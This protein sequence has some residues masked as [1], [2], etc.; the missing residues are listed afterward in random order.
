VRL[1]AALHVDT[2]MFPREHGA[3]GQVAFPLVTSLAVAGLTTGPILMALAVLALFLAHEPLVI[4]LG[5]RG[6][7]ALD[8]LGVRAWVCFHLAVVVATASGVL[9]FDRTPAPWRWTFAVPMVPAA[10]LFTALIV[11]RDEKS[12]LGESSAAL[13]FSAAALPVCAAAGHPAAGAAIALAF[14]VLFVVATLAVRVV[15]LRTRAGG[16]PRAVRTTRRATFGVAAAGVIVALSAVAMGALSW[17]AVV[18]SMPG[19]GFAAAMA[20]RPPAATRLKKVG[21]TLVAVSALTSV[22]LIITA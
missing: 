15:V 13:A 4:L 1:A 19:V 5:L 14:A 22:L 3:Y 10:M 17:P 21:W 2:T 18:A 16:N 12:A 6:R 7:R 8:G 11:R 20:A 9:A